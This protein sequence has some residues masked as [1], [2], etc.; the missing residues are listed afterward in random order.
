MKQSN[1]NTT[2]C[3][4][5]EGYGELAKRSTSWSNGQ[6][7]PEMDLIEC[8]DCGGTGQVEVETEDMEGAA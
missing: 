6:I 3:P 5:C 4:H 1:T 7:Y 8:P 2:T